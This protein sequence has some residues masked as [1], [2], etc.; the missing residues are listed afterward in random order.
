MYIFLVILF[1][2]VILAVCN[3]FY[4]HCFLRLFFLLSLP[5]PFYNLTSNYWN[6]NDVKIILP[7]FHWVKH[8][9]WH[10]G[11]MSTRSVGGTSA[12]QTPCELYWILRINPYEWTFQN[13][14]ISFTMDQSTNKTT[15][16]WLLEVAYGKTVLLWEPC[17]SLSKKI[18]KIVWVV[19]KARTDIL[20]ADLVCFEVQCLPRSAHLNIF[21]IFVILMTSF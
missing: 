8:I 13:C 7:S 6:R 5:S 12:T 16:E 2:F 4:S 3:Y 18:E 15:N 10:G 9:G 1:S 19:R 11:K 17:Y 20:L 21:P 14:D